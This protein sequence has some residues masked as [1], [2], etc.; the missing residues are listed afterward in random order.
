MEDHPV[1]FLSKGRVKL[2]GIIPNPINTNVDLSVYR[3]SRIRKA[4]SDD[5]RIIIVLQVLPVNF[6]EI[7]IG[8]KYVVEVAQGFSFFFEDSG[9]KGL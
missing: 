1:K 5:I 2:M 3:L 6:Q 4:E 9:D 7:V 8:T